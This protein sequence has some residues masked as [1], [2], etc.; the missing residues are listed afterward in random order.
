MN[1]M[2]SEMVK[3]PTLSEEKDCGS[4][5]WKPGVEVP[6]GEGGRTGE[7]PRDGGRDFGFKRS[8]HTPTRFEVRS[9][10]IA[11]TMSMSPSPS[12]E[13]RREE[14]SALAT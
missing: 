4:A 14:P 12:S 13:V 3:A 11:L 8:G 10:A 5:G 1:G 2:L 6:G 9:L 7:G